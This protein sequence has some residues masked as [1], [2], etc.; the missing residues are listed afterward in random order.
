MPHHCCWC[1]WRREILKRITL[2]FHGFWSRSCSSTQVPLNL[3]CCF[4]FTWIGLVFGLSKSSVLFHFST[5]ELRPNE[6]QNLWLECYVLMFQKI[7]LFSGLVRPIIWIISW[8]SL[9][10]KI[11]LSNTEGL[12]HIHA[13]TALMLL[14]SVSSQLALSF[15]APANI[16]WWLTH[17]WKLLLRYANV[18]HHMPSVYSKPQI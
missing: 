13:V 7:I 4:W 1:C 15:H 10:G 9:V 18:K 14:L 5:L 16:C 2:R 17:Y 12:I 11:S 6:I 8:G 3:H